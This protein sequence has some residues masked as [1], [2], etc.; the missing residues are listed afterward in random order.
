MVVGIG[1]Y[2]NRTANATP[3]FIRVTQP[4][5]TV[6]VDRVQGST[7]SLQL[8]S[9]QRLSSNDTITKADSESSEQTAPSQ[10]DLASVRL[11]VDGQPDTRADAALAEMLIREQADCDSCDQSCQ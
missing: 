6:N 2:W 7:S 4:T 3:D 5:A 1:T 11:R 10:N 9:G 8:A